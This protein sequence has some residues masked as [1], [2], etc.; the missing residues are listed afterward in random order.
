MATVKKIT[1]LTA[2]TSVLPYASELFGIY[3]PLL[4]WK[5]GR[6]KKR[7]DRG[8][9]IDKAAL[10]K[11]FKDYFNGDIRVQ[12]PDKARMVIEGINAGSPVQQN[13]KAFDSVVLNRIASKLPP[14]DQYKDDVWK[15]LL[16]DR[17]FEG[18]FKEDVI[19]Q[20]TEHFNT[21]LKDTETARLHAGAE[22]PS[23]SPLT[24]AF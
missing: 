14:A 1:D 8:M 21:A 3:Q 15:S 10:L 24:Q 23:K 11:R 5:S 7:F 9:Q 18:I 20:Y 19:P 4:G 2:Y 16:S 6:M 22:D 17:N 13:F 12:F